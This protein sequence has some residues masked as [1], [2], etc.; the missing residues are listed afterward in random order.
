MLTIFWILLCLGL[1]VRFDNWHTP[2][3]N[4]KYRWGC[5]DQQEES[6][7]TNGEWITTSN[8]RF[9]YA[10]FMLIQM[11]SK[12]TY[13]ECTIQSNN[14]VSGC[15]DYVLILNWDSSIWYDTTSSVNQR[16][17]RVRASCWS[18]QQSHRYW[19]ASPLVHKSLLHS[20]SMIVVW[21]ML[22][23]WNFVTSLF[24][25]R[26]SRPTAH[27]NVTLWIYL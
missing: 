26:R 24:V 2:R 7:Q 14:W 22:M 6:Q 23:S 9:T 21:Q 4:G 17:C 16:H 5:D 15:S 20:H 27:C 11:K 10:V 19:Q 1:L 13:C 18:H 3:W 12:V 8:S 25:C